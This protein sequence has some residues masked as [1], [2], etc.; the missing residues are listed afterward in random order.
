[1]EGEGERERER[2]GDRDMVLPSKVGN[3]SPEARSPPSG[4]TTAE[5]RGEDGVV[6]L[7]QMDIHIPPLRQPSYKYPVL[8]VELCCSTHEPWVIE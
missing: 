6:S 3:G 2:H 7:S 4:Q 1:M 5:S 8:S